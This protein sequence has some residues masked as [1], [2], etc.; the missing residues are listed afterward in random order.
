MV[1]RQRHFVLHVALH[2]G[3]DAMATEAEQARQNVHGQTDTA[4]AKDGLRMRTS[5]CVHHLR[6][7]DIMSPLLL[8]RKAW[9]LQPFVPSLN[10]TTA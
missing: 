1:V 3:T 5:I 2:A 4:G 10:W 8:R 6:K 7:Q 9:I